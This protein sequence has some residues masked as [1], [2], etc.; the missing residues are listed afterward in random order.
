MGGFVARQYQLWSEDQGL[1]PGEVTLWA[2][3][4]EG[5]KSRFGEPI[6]VEGS[7]PR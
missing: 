1:S 2:E 5:R 3:E 4:E 6:P 7:G